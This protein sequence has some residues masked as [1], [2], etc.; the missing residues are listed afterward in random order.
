MI[1]PN[2]YSLREQLAE[3]RILLCFNGPISRSL[4]E[5][6]GIALK[7]YLQAEPLTPASASDVFAVYIELTQ[8]IRHYSEKTKLEGSDVATVIVSQNTAGKYVVSA[9]NLVYRNDGDVLVDKISEL[10]LLDNVALKKIYKEQLRK[11]KSAT[12]TTGAGLG[13][14]DMS[15]K[16]SEP[17]K[18]EL[19][20]VSEDIAFYSVSV[21]L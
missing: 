17:L 4:I 19:K 2:L 14:I 9:G 10:A 6:I 18:A 21:E 15:R 12:A 16:A 1:L 13:I 3:E 8:N 11:P 5:E 7:K 20:S